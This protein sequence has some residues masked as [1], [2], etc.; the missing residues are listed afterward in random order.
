M[1]DQRQN[2]QRRRASDRIRLAPIVWAFIAL[3]V[4]FFSTLSG[5]SWVIHDIN[6]NSKQLVILVKEN[7]RLSEENTNRI[8]DIQKARIESC[9]TT[10]G[11]INEV[12]KPFFP[13]PP[14]TSEQQ[15]NFDKFKAIISRL[16]KGCVKQTGQE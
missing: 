15:A 4:I 7:Q 11:G 3:T 14:R 12:F 16:K 9:E 2:Y 1:N 6:N 8:A 13:P 10:Y 5:F